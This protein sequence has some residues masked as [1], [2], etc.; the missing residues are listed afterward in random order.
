MSVQIGN[1]KSIGKA[2]NFS[3][4]P[5]E[6]LELVQLVDGAVAVDG[7]NVQPNS[8][9]STEGDTVSFSATFT[10]TDAAQ[11]VDWS[12]ARTKQT[13]VLEN[14]TTISNG[15]IIIRRMSYH[16]VL[17]WRSKYCVLDIEIWKV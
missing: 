8:S 6:R 10:G 14:G 5:D 9:R 11:I 7:W 4:N 15:R 16:D 17:L 3:I 12:N 1:I 2:E 13:I